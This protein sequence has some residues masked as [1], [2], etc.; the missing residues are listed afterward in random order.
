MPLKIV[1]TGGPGTGKTTLIQEL[2]KRNFKCTPEISRQVTLMARKKGIEYLFLKE[3]LLFSELLL[4]GREKQYLEAV[5]SD[6]KTV[7]FDRGIPDVHAYLDHFKTTYPDTFIQ[8]SNLYRYDGIFI[9]PPWKE[10]YKNDQERF[11]TYESS[12][13]IYNHLKEAYSLLDYH[14]VE[15]PHGK[16]QERTNFILDHL[17]LL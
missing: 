12:I 11:E 14:V 8:K 15:V 13:S 3:P 7:F 4:E 6:A 16:V 5:N 9:L 10:I 17:N 1:I 2:E